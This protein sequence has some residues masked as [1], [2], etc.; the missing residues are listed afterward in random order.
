[1]NAKLYEE[2]S[3]V[4][5]DLGYTLR[6]N[7]S[8]TENFE[9]HY[10][11]YYEIFLT[12]S[13]ASI[14]MVNG[15]KLSLPAHSLS[16][17]RP[18]D[19]HTY[20]KE[21]DFSFVNL[22]FS[23]D[24]MEKM[25]IC[26]DNVFTPLINAEMPPLI[27]LSPSEFDI[28]VK[29]LNLL[30]TIDIA[31]INISRYKMKTTLC[32]ILSYFITDKPEKTSSTPMWL[33]DLADTL[34]KTENINFTLSDMSKHCGKTREHIA[35]SFK[36]YLGTTVSEYMNEQKLN[37]GANLLI[38][39]NLSVIDICYECGFQ[40]LSWFYRKFKEKYSVSPKKFR[41]NTN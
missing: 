9:L 35:R 11:N 31:D 32:E 1:M 14:Q 17:V 38:N 4:N 2:K 5:P 23:A 29:K 20:I 7:Y 18:G 8:S 39:T 33:S 6:M 19:I 24:T 13:G 28:C 26:F 27:L 22:T 15:K 25:N 12:I 10:H 16:F 36:K 3:Y 34:K 30:N 37:Y 21:G 40:N 41:S